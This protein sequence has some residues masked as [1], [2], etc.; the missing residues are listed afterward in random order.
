MIFRE[1]RAVIQAGAAVSCMSADRLLHRCFVLLVPEVEGNLVDVRRPRVYFSDAFVGCVSA[2]TFGYPP[3]SVGLCAHAHSDII[4]L[5]AK[6]ARLAPLPLSRYLFRAT[7]EKKKKKARVV[8][9]SCATPGWLSC[10][11]KTTL[12]SV[13][14]HTP[15]CVVQ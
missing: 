9:P 7:Q 8:T 12:E 2:K 13:R 5:C 10:T 6:T 1:G 14:L 11:Y 4:P 3:P 15:Q